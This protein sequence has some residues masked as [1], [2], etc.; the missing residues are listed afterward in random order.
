MK[1]YEFRFAKGKLD[2]TEY[3]VKETAK[4][5]AILHGRIEYN[6][7][8]RIPKDLI[9][10]ALDDKWNGVSCILTEND[11]ESARKILINF[12]ENNKIPSC[13][14]SVKKAKEQLTKAKNEL[15]HLKMLKESLGE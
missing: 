11:I 14:E 1:L 15:E 12:W 13:E 10:K 4:Q 5:Y 9:G 2:S 3:E 8:S 7:L 6:Y